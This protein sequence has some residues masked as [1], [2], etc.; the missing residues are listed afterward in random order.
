MRVIVHS[1]LRVRIA[2]QLEQLALRSI[3]TMVDVVYVA[4]VGVSALKEFL[5]IIDE[6]RDEE[7]VCVHVGRWLHVHLSPLQLH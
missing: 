4:P 2:L 1:R 6:N 7:C 5:S 3:V